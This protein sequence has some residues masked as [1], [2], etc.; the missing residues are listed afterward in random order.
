MHV[1]TKSNPKPERTAMHA[2]RLD[3]VPHVELLESAQNFPQTGKLTPASRGCACIH[4]HGIVRL[5]P[6]CRD[7]W[8]KLQLKHGETTLPASNSPQTR[9]NEHKDSG[10]IPETCAR[11]AI[12]N[13]SDLAHL[14]AFQ[15]RPSVEAFAIFCKPSR[16]SESTLDSAC[17]GKSW[18]SGRTFGG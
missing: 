3:E 11:S 7:L 14:A 17:C 8:R 6:L 1:L 2:F 12:E 16:Y 10:G 18:W 5:P 15:Q 13:T 4:L 9:A